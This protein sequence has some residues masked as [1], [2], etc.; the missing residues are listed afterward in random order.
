VT[1]TRTATSERDRLQTI[2]LISADSHITPPMEIYPERLPQQLRHRAPR[3]EKREKGEY[4]VLEGR[5]DRNVTETEKKRNECAPEERRKDLA[6]DGVVAEV[7]YGGIQVMPDVEL[8]LACARVYNDWLAETFVP[9]RGRFATAATIPLLDAEAA[10]AELRRAARLGLRP[11]A[12]GAPPAE[13]PLNSPDYEPL[14]AEG[15][16]LGMPISIH[17]GGGADPVR[18]HGAGGAI[19]N[20]ALATSGSI[21]PLA[22]LSASG[23]LERYPKLQVTLVECGIGWLAWA[24][25]IL[26]ES[27]IKHAHWTRP[28]LKEPPSFYIKRQMRLTFQE[29]PVG[30]ALR[31]FT[32]AQLL[33][34]GSDYP[35]HEGTWPH[36]R[37]A[38]AKQFSGIPE[39]EV[40]QIVRDN[41]RDLYGFEAD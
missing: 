38:V 29:D 24:M 13:R 37:E 25:H 30:L 10:V 18:F 27:Y 40:R 28:K 41:A 16:D 21:V 22:L 12:L 9:Y 23:V 35:H 2:P 34:W 4:L 5:H 15:Q 39:A 8:T 31:P 26:D 17:T 33:M 6:R 14:W 7:V 36:S 32:G 1:T 20:Y 3:I 11:A 19:V